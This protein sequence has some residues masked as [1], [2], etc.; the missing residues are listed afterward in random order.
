[1]PANPQ[2]KTGA[3]ALASPFIA[4]ALIALMSAAIY[5]GPADIYLKQARMLE[6]Q[7]KPKEAAESYWKAAQADLQ[8]VRL[9]HLYQDAAE[10][11]GESRKALI[12]YA[13]LRKLYPKDWRFQYLYGRLVKDIK[14]KENAYR[15]AISLDPKAFWPHYGL[16]YLY[17]VDGRNGQ[18]LKEFETARKIEPKNADALVGAGYVDAYSGR[19]DQAITTFKEALQLNPACIDAYLNLGYVYKRIGKL[20]DA[21]EMFQQALQID[22]NN[23]DAHNNLGTVFHRLRL[24]HSA[25][26]EY[27]AALK[28]GECP[29]PEVV[30]L[31]IGLAYHRLGKDADAIKAYEKAI[32]IRPN[33]AYAH[34][35]LAK[36]LFHLKQY[37]KARRHAELAQKQGYPV[38]KGFL[39]ALDKATQNATAPK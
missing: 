12:R 34:N 3:N 6:K 13:R 36:A 27:K 14:I 20:T 4:G 2:R 21:Q 24:Y 38:A 31:N 29:A 9:H 7:K 22:P 5:A 26:G 8:N 25:I 35:C 28:T 16:G 30:W 18:A 1:M 33:F 11:A 39:G 32:E 17:A 10:R 37:D 15:K 19:N 23:A